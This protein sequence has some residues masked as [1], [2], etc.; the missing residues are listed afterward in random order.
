MTGAKQDPQ[1]FTVAVG[2]RAGQ[3]VSVHAQRGQHGQ[4][5]VDRVGLS[6]AAAG[7]AVGL[8]TLNEEQ[9]GGGDR[10]G[11]P[12]AVAAGSSIDT[13]SRGPGA[14]STIHASSSA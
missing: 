13:T 9:T 10:T 7:R 2:A 8:L 3:P 1:C 4:V 11:Q 6:F 12:E 14:C 5:R